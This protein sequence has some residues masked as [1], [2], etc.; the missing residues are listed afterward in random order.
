MLIN[1][2]RENTELADVAKLFYGDDLPDIRLSETDGAYEIFIGS[3]VFRYGYN[4]ADYDIIPQSHRSG[5]MSKIALYD[6]LFAFTGR[7]MPWGALTG[8]R[9]TKLFYE[10]LKGGKTHSEATDI[11]QS[12]YRVDGKR[13]ELLRDIVSAQQGRINYSSDHINL[14]VHVPYCTTRCTY[15]SFV[16]APIDKNKAQSRTYVSLL[17]D[18]IA[19]SLA[20][21]KEHGKKVLSVYIGGGTPTALDTEA[22]EMLMDGIGRFDCEYTCEAGRPDTVTQE[23]ADIMKAHNVTRVCVNPQTLCERTLENIGRRH[24]VSDFYKAYDIVR[25][26]GFDINCDLIAGLADETADDFK[27]SFDGVKKLMPQNITVHSLSRK[28]GSVI[29]YD[30][31]DNK[32]VEQMVEHALSQRGEYIPYYLYR[33][34]RQASNLE[35]IGFTLESAQCVNNITTMEETVGVMA[36]GAGAISKFVSDGTICRFAN[37]RDVALYIN[38]FDE[39]VRA[40]LDFFHDRFSL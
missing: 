2:I 4:D 30:R 19:R 35:N 26:C 6:A 37:M 1:D 17:C 24:S 27:R 36:C 18:E 40:K 29:R 8:V 14:Y 28:N 13:A 20:L 5:R 7:K 38:S 12:V 23:K 31:N 22:F 9:P 39:K 33:Q 16:S 25:G 10:C 32:A 3:D 15:C 11:M 34:K 21:L